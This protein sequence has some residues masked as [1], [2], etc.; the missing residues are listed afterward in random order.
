MKKTPHKKKVK[1]FKVMK[2][3]D[4]ERVKEVEETEEENVENNSLEMR[5]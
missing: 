3:Y 5:I 1:I 2:W 4:A